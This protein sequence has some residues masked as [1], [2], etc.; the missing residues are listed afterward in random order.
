MKRI[1]SQLYKLYLKIKYGSRLVLAPGITIPF[2]T[3]LIIDESSVIN[4]SKGVMIR[5]NV[6]LRA[7]KNSSL[8]VG[9]LVKL[10]NFV[11]IISTNDSIIK[12]GSGSKIGLGTVFNGGENITVEEKTLISGYV[13]LQ[14]SMHNHDKDGDI[15]D[16]GYTYGP[17]YIGRGSWVGVHAV[18]FPNVS[19]GNRTI[20]GSNAVVTQSF[21]AGSIIGGIP[22]KRLK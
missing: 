4:I 1:T 9:E 17:I 15:I 12:I 20:V 10:D 3:T 14:T 8:L 11:R 5:N 2:G 22:A 16:N 19:L 18:I 13:Y 7:T 6:E 21:N